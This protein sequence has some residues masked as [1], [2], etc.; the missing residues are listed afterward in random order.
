MVATAAAAYARAV[1]AVN[2]APGPAQATG[3]AELPPNHDTDLKL[4]LPDGRTIVGPDALRRMRSEAD[5]ILWFAGNQFF[6]MDALIAAFQ[7]AHPGMGVG[8]LTLPAGLLLSAI[9]GGG[10]RYDGKDYPGTPDL[11]ASVNLAHLARLKARGMM[12]TYA[13]YLHNELQIMVARGNPKRITGIDDLARSDVRTTMPNPVNE[14]I[15]Q[16]YAREVLERHGIWQALS[17]GRSCVGCQVT[18]RTWFAAVHHRETP[19]RIREGLSDAG[20]VYATEVTAALAMGAPVEG[21]ALPPED[22][23]RDDIAYVVGALAGSPRS[24][25]AGKF[26]AFL[27]TPPAQ[28][29]YTRFGFMGASAEELRLKPIP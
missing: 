3:L 17:G 24:A 5:L 26:L 21:V 20:I 8:L 1:P 25:A 7:Q 18:E 28:Q 12:A 22:S 14:G 29:A 23:R 13:T 6:A 19:E 4:Y 27:A 2:P 15:M 9:E 11:Y 16:F 10:W